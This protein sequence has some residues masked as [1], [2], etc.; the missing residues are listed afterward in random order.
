MQGDTVKNNRRVRFCLYAKESRLSLC[1]EQEDYN[2]LPMDEVM[3]I[4]KGLSDAMG[5]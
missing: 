5:E 4:A 3:K 2:S 1:G